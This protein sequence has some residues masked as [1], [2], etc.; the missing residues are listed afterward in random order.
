MLQFVNLKKIVKNMSVKARKPKV[1]IAANKKNMII[2][3]RIN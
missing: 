3:D 1:N 2:Y